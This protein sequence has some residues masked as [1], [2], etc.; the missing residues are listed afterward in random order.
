M[1][2]FNKR[3]CSIIVWVN[4]KMN[5]LWQIC[6]TA[7]EEQSWQTDEVMPS[8]QTASDLSIYTIRQLCCRKAENDYII[9]EII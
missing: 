1:P 4:T 3:L 8:S 7:V 2:L 9:V 6:L 5:L